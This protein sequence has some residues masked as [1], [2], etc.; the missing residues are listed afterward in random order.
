MCMEIAENSI[1]WGAVLYLPILLP[2]DSA[3]L[4]LTCRIFLF[5][6]LSVKDKR[7]D[8][9]KPQVQKKLYK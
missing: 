6:I 3:S 2:K 1:Q 9:S 4:Y 7:S 5:S 8:W